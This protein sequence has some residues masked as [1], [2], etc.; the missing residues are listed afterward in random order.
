MSGKMVT[1]KS[2]S[3]ICMDFRE[4]GVRWEV[5]GSDV[6]LCPMLSFGV[7]GFEPLVSAAIELIMNSL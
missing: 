2:E 3:N 4:V 1:W 6:V 7:S 5:N